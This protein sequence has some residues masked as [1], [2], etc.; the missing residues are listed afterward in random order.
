MTTARP[1][2]SPAL[3]FLILCPAFAAVHNP[4]ELRGTASN[5]R[6]SRPNP[7]VHKREPLLAS[8]D[9]IFIERSSARLAVLS[10][11]CGTAFNLSKQFGRNP[12]IQ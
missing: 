9:L 6:P 4:D 10:W 1:G 3:R 11:G 12:V 2:S 7:L 5:I 8:K